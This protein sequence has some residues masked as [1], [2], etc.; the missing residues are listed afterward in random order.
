MKKNLQF[1]AQSE[2]DEKTKQM[3]DLIREMEQQQRK[4]AAEAQFAD[5]N[6]WRVKTA[7][8]TEQ[9]VDELLKELEAGDETPGE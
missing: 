5:N 3:Q 9:D 8:E 7:A 1:V 4:D 6:F 2:A